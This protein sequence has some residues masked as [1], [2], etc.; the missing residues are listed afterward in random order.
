MHR[1][2]LKLGVLNPLRGNKANFKK[3]LIDY[4]KKNIL[5]YNIIISSIK[6]KKNLQDK[7]WTKDELLGKF[8]ILIWDIKNLFN[9]VLNEILKPSQLRWSIYTIL[10]INRE[11]I[12]YDNK[13]WINENYKII[14]KWVMDELFSIWPVV[15]Y[16]AEYPLESIKAF[17]DMILPVENFIKT[18]K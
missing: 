4:W 16:I 8:K 6:I 5:D 15:E 17:W 12:G 2:Q 1:V 9:E 11:R 10:W 14:L 7:Y 3:F 13:L 18:I